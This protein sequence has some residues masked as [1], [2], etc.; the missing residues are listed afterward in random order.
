M[1]D[2][3][4]RQFALHL[5]ELERQ[6]AT[7]LQLAQDLQEQERAQV[8]A[9]EENERKRRRVEEEMDGLLARSLEAQEGLELETQLRLLEQDGRMARE[10]DEQERQSLPPNDPRH[11]LAVEE[12]EVFDLSTC[13][14]KIDVPRLRA[15]LADLERDRALRKRRLAALTNDVLAGGP[16]AKQQYHV[17]LLL[18]QKIE[19]FDRFALAYD[20]CLRGGTADAEGNILREVR[21][22]SRDRQSVGRLYSSGCMEIKIDGL[23]ERLRRF[24]SGSLQGMP[25][26]LRKVLTAAFCYDVDCV[27]SE[28]RNLCSLA[29]RLNIQGKIKTIMDYMSNRDDWLRKIS[30]LQQCSPDAAKRVVTTL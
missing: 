21:Y 16:A 19:L 27:N 14:E 15:L 23:H 28:I 8:S 2:E 10:L 5:E 12:L 22:L 7:D 13:I 29:I 26:C 1:S 30:S 9:S 17:P 20:A 25:N 4:V 3:A 24:R 18:F 11:A 6:Q